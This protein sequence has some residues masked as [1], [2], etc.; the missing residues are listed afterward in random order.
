MSLC[1]RIIASV[2]AVASMSVPGL[3]AGQLE[4]RLGADCFK[5]HSKSSWSTSVQS[6]QG[7]VR[8]IQI[9]DFCMGESNV[10]QLK[11]ENPTGEYLVNLAPIAFVNLKAF[12]F[13][14]GDDVTIEGLVRSN[15]GQKIITA[16]K[17]ELKGNV[18][19]IRD[20][21]GKPLWKKT[22]ENPKSRV[23]ISH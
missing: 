2:I 22:S 3:A 16:S 19:N 18:L 6:I 8:D 1:L 5:E 7:K 4:G 12:K 21:T 13:S 9:E 15:S 20:K 11:I 10:L 17:V 14:S 23:G